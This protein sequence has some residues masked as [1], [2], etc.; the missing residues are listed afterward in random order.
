MTY[1]ENFMSAFW[2]FKL[3]EIALKNCLG[4]FILYAQTYVHLEQNKNQALRN[5]DLLSEGT[6]RPK[7]HL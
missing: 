4:D 2:K 5:V 3:R 7:W 6:H 1:L